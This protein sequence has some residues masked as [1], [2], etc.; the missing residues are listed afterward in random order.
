MWSKL[1][2]FGERSVGPVDW[3]VLVS[4]LAFALALTD[5][6][7]FLSTDVGGKIATLEAM[8]D[9]GDVSPDLGYWAEAVDPDGSLYPMWSTTHVDDQWVNVTSLPML[10]AMLPLYRFGGPLAAG[11]VPLI[12]TVAAAA[13]AA[14]LAGEIGGRRRATFWMV[15]AASPLTIYALDLWEHS[16]GVAAMV[17][18][19]TLSLRAS[20]DEGFWRPAAAAGLLF[21]VAAAMR[22]EALVYGFVAGV[23][24]IGRLWF[25]SPRTSF[26][27]RSVRTFFPATALVLGA[28]TTTAANAILEHAMIG[29]IPRTGRSMGTASAVGS[30]LGLRL[31]EAMI[32]GASAFPSSDPL[33]LLLAVATVVLLVAVGRAALNPD[34]KAA[35]AGLYTLGLGLIA[36]LLVLDLVVEGGRFIP[37][38]AATTPVAVLGLWG[39]FR[40]PDR[41]FVASIALGSLPLVWATQFTGGANPQWGGRYILTTGTVL[42]AI[43]TAVLVEPRA[44]R[45]LARVAAAGFAITIFG[46]GWTVYRT[47]SFG[48]AMDQL[49]AREEPVLVFSDS[50]LSREGGVHA[51]REEWM[52]APTD[53]TRQEAAH[54]L[55]ALGVDRIGYVQQERGD[56]PTVLPG[57]EVVG[58]DRVRL[59]GDLY[60]LVSTQEPI[61]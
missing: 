50:H 57:W 43:A 1:S 34:A 49:A 19:I 51:Y 46:V 44:Q 23:T 13:A 39:A 11:V 48:A 30:D 15:G 18:A 29:G 41:A 31:R 53:E 22:Q 4:I 6:N 58:I 24:L 33:W 7:G 27:S 12:G 52:A 2:I 32:T 35:P 38:L 55:V 37:G 14:W 17:A 42:V 3:F 20:R 61:E 59:I 45:V 5:P 28:L 10:Y 56:D 8:D 26:W 60:L 47:A 54:A 21:G 40:D 9:R 16:L 36:S 25:F